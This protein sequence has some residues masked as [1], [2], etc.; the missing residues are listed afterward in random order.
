M[1]LRTSSPWHNVPFTNAD[2]MTGQRHRHFGPSVRRS[3]PKHDTT[4]VTSNRIVLRSPCG[5]LY[6]P[7]LAPT[8]NRNPRSHPPYPPRGEI[9]HPQAIGKLARGV[10]IPHFILQWDLW[11]PHSLR[12]R[13]VAKPHIGDARHRQKRRTAS[14]GTPML[15]S[16]GRA[17][18]GALARPYSSAWS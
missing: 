16:A 6:W 18:R 10:G 2:I 7:Y 14:L 13:P 4:T 15:L 11:V 3:L 17:D 9:D 8:S 5:C 1:K 12:S